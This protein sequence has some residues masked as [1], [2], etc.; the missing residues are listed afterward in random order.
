MTVEQ[1]LMHHGILGMKWG[2]RRFQNPD[3]TLTDAGRKRVSKEYKKL[4]IKG[5]EDLQKRYQGL[6]VKAHNK[7]ADKMNS[8]E[9][10][11]FNKAQEKKH[12]ADFA[13]RKEYETEYYDFVN[14]QLTQFM[15]QELDSFYL[16]N[17][18][19]QKADALIKKYNMTAWDDLAKSNAAGIAAARANKG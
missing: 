15:N 16:S 11:K 1:E 19:Y 12:G 6:Y 7:T 17:A 8:G 13:K 4:A 10:D 5:D 9:I 14:K 2:V 3:G 18:N